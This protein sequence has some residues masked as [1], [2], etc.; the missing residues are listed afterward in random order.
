[1]CWV[2]TLCLNEL[3]CITSVYVY[4]DSGVASSESQDHILPCYSPYFVELWLL[5]SSI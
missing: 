5:V 2:A 3:N 4:D 1:M